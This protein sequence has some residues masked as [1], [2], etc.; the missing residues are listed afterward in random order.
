MER[1]KELDLK[2]REEVGADKGEIIRRADQVFRLFRK[3]K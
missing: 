1:A 3:E 2:C